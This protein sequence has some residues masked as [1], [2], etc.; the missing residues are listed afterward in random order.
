LAGRRNR[1]GV[2]VK[3]LEGQVGNASR[4]IWKSVDKNRSRIEQNVSQA[5]DNLKLK[6]Q[7]N[8]NKERG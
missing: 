7:T 2:F 6:L 3:N 5:L 8:L 4:L 1:K